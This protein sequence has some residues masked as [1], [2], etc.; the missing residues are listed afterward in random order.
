[1]KQM[2]NNKYLSFGCLLLSYF[3]RINFSGRVCILV[4]LSSLFLPFC[5]GGSEDPGPK[6]EDPGPKVEDPPV[7]AP[8]PP[9]NQVQ[10]P[11]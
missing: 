4:I 6:V 11:K 10:R 3:S 2:K 8:P 5:A 7:V 9:I 1:M